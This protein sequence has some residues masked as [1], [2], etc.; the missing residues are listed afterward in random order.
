VQIN[1]SPMFSG[2]FSKKDDKAQKAHHGH[3]AK[4]AHHAGHHKK[5]QPAFGA[6]TA[7]AD[8]FQRHK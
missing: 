2:L 7:S 8:S 4:H 3:G 6:V 5:H 1:N